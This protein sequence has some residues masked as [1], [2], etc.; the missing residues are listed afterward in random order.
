MTIKVGDMAPAFALKDNRNKNVSLSDFGGKRI[1]LSWHPLAWTGVC[2][3][4]MKA[5]EVSKDIL[6]GLNTV[7]LGISVDS[8][9][10]KN[11]W[12][13]DLKI[14]ETRLLSDFWPHGRVA[15][16]YGIFR[17]SEGFSERATIVVDGSGMVVWVKIYDIPELPDLDEVIAFLRG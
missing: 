10:S 6:A 2:A 3:D 4:Q 13:K 17:E 11:A 15:G 8:V 9:P 1:L 5:L 16:L 14:A 12:A 7:A